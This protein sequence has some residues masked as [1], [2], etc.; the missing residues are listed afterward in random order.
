VT[1]PRTILAR[2]LDS[3]WFRSPLK[4]RATFAAAA[5]VVGVLC[6]YPRHYVARADLLPQDTGGG[7]SGVIGQSGALVSLGALIGSHQSIE[8]DVTVARSEAVLRDVIGR[9][10]LIGRGRGQFRDM[11]DAERK[12]RKKVDVEA[13]RGSILQVKSQDANPVF[14]RNFVAA[15]AWAIQNR[16]TTLTLRQVAAKR[17]VANERL[18]QSAAR[19]TAAQRAITNYRSVNKLAAPEIQLGAAVTELAT[20]QARLQAKQVEL[21]MVERFTT[22]SNIQLQSIQTEITSIQRQIADAET[23]SGSAGGP[24]LATIA[25][26]SDAY[27]NLYRDEQF[28]ESLYEVYSKYVEEVIIDEM[29]A[30]ANMEVIE[31]AYV[32]PNRQ[33]NTAAVALLTLLILLAAGC[34]YYIVAPPVGRR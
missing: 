8:V 29:S 10:Q 20:L 23:A 17:A 4:R 11:P 16:L 21:Q 7:L 13:I 32:D 5:F 27:F 2:I 9:M 14:A 25:L 31:P 18:A 15:Y 24:K 12:L 3:R 22:G 26:G 33:F 19:L 34:E 6:L 28:A 1:P 30:N